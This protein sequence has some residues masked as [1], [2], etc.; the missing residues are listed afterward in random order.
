MYVYTFILDPLQRSSSKETGKGDHVYNFVDCMAALSD[1]LVEDVSTSLTSATPPI[2]CLNNSDHCSD[3]T[4][5]DELLSP[6]KESNPRDE[7]QLYTLSDS[8]FDDDD[9]DESLEATPPKSDSQLLTK[10]PHVIEY[11]VPQTMDEI[12][13]AFSHCCDDVQPEISPHDSFAFQFSLNI[14]ASLSQVAAS[15][16]LLVSFNTRFSNH[17]KMFKSTATAG[18]CIFRE[19]VYIHVYGVTM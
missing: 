11:S 8:E 5:D 17:E 3:Q 12:L 13:S 4:L 2:T 14:D 7:F 9:N 18:T 6:T 16:G 15:M 19:C 10:E 1:S